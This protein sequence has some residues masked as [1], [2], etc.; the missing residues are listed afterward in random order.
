ML[1]WVAERPGPHKNSG[2]NHS[3]SRLRTSP[4]AAAAML[5]RA[6]TLGKDTIVEIAHAP[7]LRLLS[8]GP[9]SASLTGPTGD[10]RFKIRLANTEGR[11]STAS[12]L[13][14][15]QF[16]WRGYASES[17]ADSSANRVTLAAFGEI[18]RPVGTVTIGIDS[19]AGL[20]VEALYPGEIR[21][22]RVAG[23]RLG[24][25]TQLAVD[26]MVKSKAVLAAIFHIA[27]IYAHRICGCTDLVIEVNPR[28]VRFYETML[29]F[30]RSGERRMDPRVR[31]PAVL[32]RLPLTHAENE[33]ARLGGHAECAKRMRTLYPLFFS[34]AEERGIEGRLRSLH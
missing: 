31:A 1:D 10:S 17:L 28:H 23:K 12:Y 3:H 34:S 8:L 2:V 24:E 19:P 30:E 7:R 15:R 18:D 25:F 33:I 9:S 13:I 14:K 11:R 20:V 21:A 4:A 16:A 5:E 29:G 32:L 27:Y 6:D 26:S 22:L